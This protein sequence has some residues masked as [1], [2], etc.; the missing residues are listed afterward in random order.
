MTCK[1]VAVK[2]IRISSL[3]FRRIERRLVRACADDRR[4]PRP[5]SAVAM[6]TDV[7]RLSPFYP[8]S[9]IARYEGGFLMFECFRTL[10]A[11]D[12][13]LYRLCIFVRMS[14]IRDT[15]HWVQFIVG[16]VS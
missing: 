4:L 11:S 3:R 1:S 2:L 12:V 16:Y 10:F 15:V 5:P 14:L 6:A 7:N 9:V 8:A 13:Y